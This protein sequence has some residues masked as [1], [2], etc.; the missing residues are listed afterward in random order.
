MAGQWY[1][2]VFDE[3]VGPISASQLRELARSGS[4]APD[5]LVRASSED[6]WV[7][8]GEVRG[9]LEGGEQ[10][11]PGS[12][13]SLESAPPPGDSGGPKPPP[14][15]GEQPAGE[16][17][18]HQSSDGGSRGGPFWTD[19]L[20][21]GSPQASDA[22]PA[23]VVVKCPNPACGR[24][25][26][27]RRSALG[28]ISV[29][30]HCGWEF[31][32]CTSSGE[33][34]PPDGQLRT[35]RGLSSAPAREAPQRLGRFEIVSR[36]GSGAFGTVYRAYDP[37]L[38]REVALKVPR[39]AAM[40]KPEVRARFLREPKAAAQLRHPHIVPVYDAGTDGE[41]YYIASA[42][43]EGN[44]LKELIDQ[45]RLD[46]RRA[47]Q[48]VRDLA[49]ALDY[50]HRMGVVHR[51]VK[52]ANVMI[53]TEGDALL[54]DFGLARLESSDEKLTRLDSVLGTPAYMAPEQA[55][56]SFGEVGPASDQ[57]SLGVILY[58]LLCGET[59]FSGPSTVVILN[60][61]SRAPDPPGSKD[62][63]VP[64]DLETICL[65]A[66]AK[67][68][69]QRYADCGALAE[70]L[71]RWLEG[72]PIQARRPGPVAEP[73]P[74][75]EAVGPRATQRSGS[76]V[77]KDLIGTK[78]S[79][80][81][82]LEQLGAGAMGLV[83]KAEDV[84]LGRQVALKFLSE[85][86]SRDLRFRARFLRE[87]RAASALNH[88]HI[89]TIHDIGEYQG[90]PFLVMELLQGQTLLE[91]LSGS[92]LVTQQLLKLA[93]QIA[94]ALQA[95]HIKGIIHRDIKSG[96]IFV[97]ER[98]QV[99]IVD[100]GLAKWL[101]QSPREPDHAGAPPPT[102]EFGEM[103]ETSPGMAVGTA[104]YMSPEQARGEQLDARSDLFSF[105]VVLYEMA[106]GKLP[107]QGNTPAVVFD[108]ILN[109]APKPPT[110]LNP[111]LPD[112]LQWIISKA[113]EKAPSDRYQS[114]GELLD[115]LRRVERALASGREAGLSS[116]EPKAPDPSP[117]I[118]VLSF[119]NI[120]ADPEN[121]YFGDGLAEELITALTKVEGLRVAAR[122]SAFQFKGQARDV[123]EIGRR[124][125]VNT[126][127]EGSIRKSGSRLRVT[128]QLVKVA[129]GYQLWSGRYDRTME[130]VFAIQDEITLTIVD[131][132]KVELAREEKQRLVK[133][134]PENVD[135]YNLY[136]RGRFYWNK[137]TGETIS[138][139]IDYFE[140]A[141]SVDPDYALAH[142]GLAD[143][144]AVLGA[145][146]GMPRREAMPNA[147]AAALKAASI[148]DTLAEAHSSLGL[149]SAYYEYDWSEARR[150]FAKALQLDPAYATAH[151]WYAMF[152]LLPTGRFDEAAQE[153]KRAQELDPITPSVNTALGWVYYFQRRY[154]RAIEA[155]Q[156]VLELAPD[157]ALTHIFLGDAYAAGGMY[158][159]AMAAYQ[160]GRDVRLFATEGLAL[161][162]A[163][164]GKR[165]EAEKLLDDLKQMLEQGHAA[166][167]GIARIYT[168]LGESDLAFQYL[169]KAYQEREP[170]L[171]W[172]D[173]DQVFD[174]L[175]SDPRFDALL[176]RMGLHEARG[177]DTPDPQV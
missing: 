6:R 12:R 61:V 65:K 139:A 97:T 52:P 98:G 62:A 131:A 53:D 48:I 172:L 67:D 165:G 66:T 116:T 31:V 16:A 151:H 18:R 27:A 117:S 130:D 140:Q 150:Q 109:R 161:T 105:A 3:V 173:V 72:Q 32:L 50:A 124:L 113:M 36:L 167:V 1:Y 103:V 5:T 35:G 133:R 54:M 135:A 153:A 71:R 87:A 64:S 102:T 159:E 142:A 17:G 4:L 41:Y 115:D 45:E 42:Y 76:L 114:A 86:V 95:A 60:V 157:H 136:L 74:G 75:D 127:L 155:H 40:D 93:M 148:D 20:A 118:A 175:R 84:R 39:A 24:Q 55:D 80:Y 29:C 82:I 141:I 152:V 25:Y 28:R 107:F 166:N 81:R 145:T 78:I 168:R 23:M 96:N 112:D 111:H 63:G 143:C 38:D 94:D 154:D 120:G 158:D 106:T 177:S 46:F 138:K 68:P 144:Y 43:I 128:A 83:Y 104:A 51:D 122:T 44:T 70:D 10:Q 77:S 110:S 100:F 8:A 132:L 2:Q 21:P 37:L 101:P 13:P 91:E 137:R 121:E 174:D 15:P 162:Y 126:V 160:R 85:Q 34:H 171:V 147:K 11:Q 99:K 14:L 30:K 89:C 58:E 134:R 90:L 7:P 164:L 26:R 49:E 88:P 149:V 119:V 79:H 163:L 59:P 92:P 146:G 129:D 19:D 56:S 69:K 176:R 73:R 57:Y 108:A 169:D 170:G 156:R 22:L 9:L 123:R 33:T 47:A 125:N